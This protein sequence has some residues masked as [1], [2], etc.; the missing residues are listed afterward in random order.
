VKFQER[1]RNKVKIITSAI[2]LF[3][4]VTFAHLISITATVPFP[5]TVPATTTAT[6]TFQVTNITSKAKVTVID[7]SHFPVGSGLSITSSTCGSLLN[8]QQSCSIQV[9]LNAPAT[10]QVIATELR[11]WAKPS[12]DGVQYPIN[13]KILPPPPL[14]VISLEKVDSTQL[15]ALRDPAV[16][17]HDGKWLI[18][19]GSTGNFHD[20]NKDF[21]TD[22]TVYD[23]A[24]QQSYS[25]PIFCSDLDPEIVKQLFSSSPQFLQDKDTLYIIGGFYTDFN[26][27]WVTLNTITAI[28]VPG[29]MAAV[30]RGDTNL[31]QYTHVRTDIE[32]FRV[33]G[34]Q[35]GKLNDHFFLA[36]GQDCEGASYCTFQKYTNS[37][38]K[39]VTDP[40]LSSVTI[41]KS[42]THA[43]DDNSGWRRR[44]YTLVPFISNH[45]DTLFAMAGPFTQSEDD[46]LVWTNGITFDDEI[47]S[48]DNFINQQS[49]QYAT[50]HLSMHSRE[51]GVTYVATFSG[52][53][54]LYWSSTGSGLVYDNT[55]P[56]GNILGL[57]TSDSFGNVQ[58]FANLTPLCSGFP[59]SSCLYMGLGAEFIPV[60]KY[61]DHRN[62]LKLDDLPRNT[63]TLVGYV[64]AGLVSPDQTIFTLPPP[65]NTPPSPTQVTNQVYAVYVLP[66]GPIANNWKNVTNMNPGN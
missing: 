9:T 63:K 4:T 59:L 39:F 29:M 2:L 65:N 43:D 36:F 26:V 6:A 24:T 25:V 11:E 32:E 3:P 31:N 40:E 46:A 66:K 28:D 33:T 19:S 30:I 62:I 55:T 51:D 8:P 21:L 1:Y 56:Y 35:L 44:D 12:A 58:E 18:V 47:H 37:I 52:L 50:S 14:P 48:N 13:I 57:I 23:P 54:N 60:D 61:F 42:I 27:A 41:V 17:T 15:P 16:A 7:Q 5:A 22:I 38:Y 49:N 34:G 45:R 53:S 64:Y 20:F 10:G